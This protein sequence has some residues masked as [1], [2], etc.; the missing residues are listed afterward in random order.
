[1]TRL[2]LTG[3]A[4]FAGHHIV[5]HVLATTDWEVVGLASFR[6]RGCPRRLAH[7][8]NDRLQV[9]HADLSAPI[10]ERLAEEIGA[11][12]YI[13]HAAAESHVE[14][15]L[16][17]PRSFIENNV[18]VTI[19]MLEFARRCRPR[20]LIQVSTDEVYGPA[21]APHRHREWEPVIPSNPY[22]ASKAAQEAVA[23]AYWRSYG[24]PMLIS[25]C[26]NLIGERQDVEKFVP[27]VMRRVLAGEAV[28]IHWDG[29]SGAIGSRHYLHARNHADALLWLLQRPQRG[30]FPDVDRPDRWHIVGEL[31]VDNLEL[32]T[33]I[34]AVIGKPLRAEYVDFHQ[35]RP[36]HDLR[37]ALDGAKLAATGWRPPVP[38]ASS[39][40]RTVEWTMRHPE[41]L[42]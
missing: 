40:E 27:M 6:H 14:R 23:I 18:A 26:M 15:S 31:E 30:C 19:T 36:G 3:V 39:L 32:A 33:M 34:A 28:P 2:L 35:S 17:E 24:V 1:M 21:V 5:E 41:W 8:E 10:N 13:I 20:A 12:D 9:L 25:N 22:S 42:L 29:L 7:L 4:G 11:V 37:Y 16:A 38:F